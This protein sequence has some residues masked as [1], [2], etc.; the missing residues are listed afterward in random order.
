MGVCLTLFAS[1]ITA[2]TDISRQK[3]S[4]GHNALT[5]EALDQSYS[6]NS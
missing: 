6:L 3:S 5:F 4:K 1:L 2:Q